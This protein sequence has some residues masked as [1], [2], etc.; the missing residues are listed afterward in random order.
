MFTDCSANLSIEDIKARSKKIKQKNGLDVIIIDHLTLMK[1]PKMS[2]RDL[3]VGYVTMNLK[4]LAKELD[5][6]VILLCQL[7]R[8]VEVS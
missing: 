1:M 6:A 5:V 7:N 3:E 2:R 4:A 8:G